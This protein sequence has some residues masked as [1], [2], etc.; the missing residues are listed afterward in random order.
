MENKTEEPKRTYVG[1]EQLKGIIGKILEAQSYPKWNFLNNVLDCEEVLGE[2]SLWLHW[3]KLLI[4]PKAERYEK[5][6]A[7][8]FEELTHWSMN[9]KTDKIKL[10]GKVWGQEK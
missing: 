4:V 9:I 7:V 1:V 2:F 10:V 3:D 6:T 8:D 5:H